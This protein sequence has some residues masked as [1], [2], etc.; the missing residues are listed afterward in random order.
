MPIIANVSGTEG[1]MPNTICLSVFIPFE[2][3][4]VCNIKLDCKYLHKWD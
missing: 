2:W 4:C 3:E 1:K